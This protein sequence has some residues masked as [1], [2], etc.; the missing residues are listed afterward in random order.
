MINRLNPRRSLMLALPILLTLGATCASADSISFNLT[1]GNNAL[2]PTFSGPYATV[3]VNRTS[4]TTAIITFDSLTQTIGGTTYKYLLGSNGAAAVNVNGTASLGSL[5]GTIAFPPQTTQALSDSGSANEDGFSAFTNTVDAFD[6]YTNSYTQIMFTLTA[7]G[8][9]TWANAGSVLTANTSGSQAAAHI[10]VCAQVSG[11]CVSTA[12]AVVTGYA[13]GT[14]TGG[15]ITNFG[16][17]PEPTSVVLLGTVFLGLTS[18][19]RKKGNSAR[20]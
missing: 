20:V 14:G 2:T 18:L 5:S 3:T 9:T 7:T 1:A 19:L 13:A 4:T 16:E 11:S 10:I 6:S 15:N 8:G 17:V 12:G